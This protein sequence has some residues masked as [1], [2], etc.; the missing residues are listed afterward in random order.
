MV[1]CPKCGTDVTTP[2]RTWPIPSR[3][4]PMQGE[5]LQVAGF[6]DCPNCKARF[7]GAVEIASRPVDTANIMNMVDRIKGIRGELLQTLKNLRDKIKTLETERA[8]LMIE[9]GK[10]RDVAESRADAL[11]NEV[12]MLREEVRSLRDLLGYKEAEAFSEDLVTERKAR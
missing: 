10:L 4:P 7:R 8:S 2:V 1:H 6:F 12:A 9:I 11:Q 3:K 5:S